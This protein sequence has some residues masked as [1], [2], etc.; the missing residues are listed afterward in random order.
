MTVLEDQTFAGFLLPFHWKYT[1]SLTNQRRF[2]VG[3][4]LKFIRKCPMASC[5][6]WHCS[7]RSSIYIR[8]KWHLLAFCV[9]IYLSLL[10]LLLMNTLI[11]PDNNKCIMVKGHVIINVGAWQLFNSHKELVLKRIAI[12]T[13]WIFD[14]K[15]NEYPI[16]LF[17]NN[18]LKLT[19]YK[20]N[21]IIID[22][23]ST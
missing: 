12:F 5:Y 15:T 19:D 21:I 7:N 16:I 9:W 17:F 22:C 3:H 6:F 8:A 23:K 4:M 10:P 18:V 20:P 2:L 1:V 14:I 11:F 13:F